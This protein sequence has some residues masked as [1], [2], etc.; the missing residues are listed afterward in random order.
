MQVC[1]QA[2]KGE[3]MRTPTIGVLLVTLLVV[4]A[5]VANVATVIAPFGARKMVP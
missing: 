4:L 3:K 5:F 1:R 2:K